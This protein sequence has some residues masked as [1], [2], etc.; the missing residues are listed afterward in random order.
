[1]AERVFPTP[2]DWQEGRR[3][4]AWALAQQGCPPHLIA[5]ALGVTA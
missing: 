2:H 5:T 1:M 3:R 4:R